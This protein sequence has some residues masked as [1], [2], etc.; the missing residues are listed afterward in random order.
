[1]LSDQSVHDIVRRAVEAGRS[2]LAS[3]MGDVLSAG[4]TLIE[5]NELPRSLLDTRSL[6]PIG[7]G[8]QFGFVY[9]FPAG[10]AALREP[11]DRR[12]SRLVP[13]RAGL[14]SAPARLVYRYPYGVL[15]GVIDEMAE[16][17]E[18]ELT[19]TITQDMKNY[20]NTQG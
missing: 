5:N 15:S 1:M 8:D 11:G 18:R 10:M 6:S 17:Y 2:L 3:S 7:A 12:Q 9:S 19:E 4:T 16:Q 14:K 20:G 13:T